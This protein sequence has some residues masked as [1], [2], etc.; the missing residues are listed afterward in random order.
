MTVDFLRVG[1]P[2]R[3]GHLD[4]TGIYFA[5]LIFNQASSCAR[6]IPRPPMREISK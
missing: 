2:E 1:Q 4:E 5:V 3:V 6:L